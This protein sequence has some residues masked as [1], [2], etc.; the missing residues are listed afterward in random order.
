MLELTEYRKS[1]REHFIGFYENNDAAHL[2]NHADEVVDNALEICRVLEK[3]DW[4]KLA[5]VAGYGHDMYTA[6]NRKDHHYMAMDYILSAEFQALGFLEGKQEHVMAAQAALTHRASWSEGYH[7][8]FS[9]VLATADR[10]RPDL[11][12]YYLRSYLYAIT[13]EGKSRDD[14]IFH[15]LI[16][17]REKFGVDGTANMP[18]L[19]FR[20]YKDELA[21][22]RK[23]VMIM[24]E[25]EMAELIK[26]DV[27]ELGYV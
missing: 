21:I 14:A 18:P 13:K 25:E 17:I 20:F 26:E 22:I 11:R 4:Y 27:E 12:K 9:E 1:V 3:P 10:G 16:H 23:K 6:V 15:S 19:F 8:E 24:T 2:I 5:I 7:S